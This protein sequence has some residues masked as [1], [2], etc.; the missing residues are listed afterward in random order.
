MSDSCEEK[1]LFCKIGLIA[2]L[3]CYRRFICIYICAGICICI[4]CTLTNVCH[5]VFELR[6]LDGAAAIFVQSAEG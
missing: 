4:C 2:E 5:E 1:T 3:L 6:G